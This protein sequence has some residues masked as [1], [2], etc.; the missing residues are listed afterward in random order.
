[1]AINGN[2][3]SISKLFDDDVRFSIPRFQ[4]SYDWE[5]N[6]VKTWLKDIRE[7]DASSNKKY[8]V[9][10]IVYTE[11]SELNEYFIVDG[12]Q[13]LTTTY[14]I[15]KIISNIY[16]QAQVSETNRTLRNELPKKIDV[17]FG[18]E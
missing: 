5:E 11:S 1:M 13:R 12:Q 16:E 3:V 2:D 8:F 15:Y 9:G 7:I 6:E 17:E 14:F 10:A 4:R 18:N